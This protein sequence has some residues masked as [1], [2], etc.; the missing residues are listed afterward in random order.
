MRLQQGKPRMRLQRLPVFRGSA[1]RAIRRDKAA[2]VAF[3]PAQGTLL[4]SVQ[5]PR[6]PPAQRRN[7]A[8]F[9]IEE[10]ILDELEPSQI[11]LGPEFPLGSGRWLLCVLSSDGASQVEKRKAPIFSELMKIKVPDAGWSAVEQGSNVLV[12]GSDGSGTVMPREVFGLWSAHSN[13]AITYT[14]LSSQDEFVRNLNTHGAFDLR[15]NIRDDI[16]YMVERGLMWSAVPV[17]V[18]LVILSGIQLYETEQ[19]RSSRDQ[20]YLALTASLENAGVTG[21]DPLVQASSLLA[22][23]AGREESNA[24]FQS[25]LSAMSRVPFASMNVSVQRMRFS[26]SSGELTLSLGAPNLQALQTVE[27]Q[28]AGSVASAVL[29]PTELREGLAVA[30]LVLTLQGRQ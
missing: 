26:R 12:R 16:A 27:S 2:T 14:E 20:A 1:E 28:F 30:D 24:A 19:A 5:L 6:L 11:C 25:L 29:G 4:L 15:R 13:S 3:L 21:G 17:L 7:A 10:Q 23:A 8:H 22:R 18:C 9:A